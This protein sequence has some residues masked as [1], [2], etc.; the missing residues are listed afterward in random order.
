MPNQTVKVVY[1]HEHISATEHSDS[2]FFAYADKGILSKWRGDKT[3]PLV[4]VLESFQVYQSD[5][6]GASGMQNVAS[7]AEMKNAFGSEDLTSVLQEILSKGKEHAMPRDARKQKQG[8]SSH[9]STR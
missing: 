2:A 9:N 7:K 5:T 6:K 1:Q 4:E 8:N 3:V